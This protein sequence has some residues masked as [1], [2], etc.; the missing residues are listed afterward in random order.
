MVGVPP[1]TGMLDEPPAQPPSDGSPPP[2]DRCPPPVVDPVDGEALRGGERF[3]C[4]RT[5]AA[6]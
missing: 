4:T 5:G 6:G 2:L 3:F 1:D